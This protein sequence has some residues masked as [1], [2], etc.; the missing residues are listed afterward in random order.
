MSFLIENFSP[1]GGNARGGNIPQD[2]IPAQDRSENSIQIFSY[3]SVD[4]IL[5]E[6]T[7]P[8]YFNELR[9]YIRR[10][11]WLDIASDIDGTIGQSIHFVLGDGSF[12]SALAVAINNGGTGYSIGD[13]VTVTYTDGTIDQKTVVHVTAVAGGVVIGLIINDPGFFS[14]VPTSLT[15]LATVG[16]GGNDLTVDITLATQPSDALVTLN[17][18]LSIV[19]I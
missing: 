13:S 19:A 11:D 9:K 2:G 7:F 18:S 3:S 4:T 12:P 8:G 6:I 10:G 17:Q 14:V 16:A 5:A 15:G 1:V